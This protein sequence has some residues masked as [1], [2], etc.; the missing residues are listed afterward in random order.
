MLTW[1]SLLLLIKFKNNNKQ[2][3]KKNFAENMGYH[4]ST[5][6][7]IEKKKM[8]CYVYERQGHKSY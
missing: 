1:L 8:I 5:S 6:G 2:S 7:K 3:I 4:K